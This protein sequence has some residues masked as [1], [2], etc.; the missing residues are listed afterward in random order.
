MKI[1]VCTP[2]QRSYRV[3]AKG[4]KGRKAW[5][6]V[7]LASDSQHTKRSM[8]GYAPESP[9][10]Q[11]VQAPLLWDDHAENPYEMDQGSFEPLPIPKSMESIFKLGAFDKTHG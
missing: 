8:P 5:V 9:T 11:P 2:M 10:V 1:K 4:K 6:K 7:P 3:E